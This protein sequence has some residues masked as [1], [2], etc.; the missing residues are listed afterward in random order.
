M[1][2][3]ILQYNPSYNISRR[4]NFTQITL[5]TAIKNTVCLKIK[6]KV[7]SLNLILS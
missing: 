3:K 5:H 4:Q 6:Q 2:I 1:V 7:T